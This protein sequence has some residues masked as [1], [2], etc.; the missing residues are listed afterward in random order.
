M[1]LGRRTDHSENGRTL[2]K[3][4]EKYTI[5][6]WNQTF[7]PI[8]GMWKYNGRKVPFESRRVAAIDRACRANST[9]ASCM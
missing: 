8:D 7:A 5:I 9:S 2:R 1:A 4:A 3:I 6:G